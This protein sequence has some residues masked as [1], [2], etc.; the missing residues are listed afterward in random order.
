MQDQDQDQNQGPKY[1]LNIEGTLYPWDQPT[2]SAADIARLGG[3]DPA[4]GVLIID[5]NNNE[6]QLQPD[7]VIE[8][9]PGLGF[10]KKVR[11]RRGMDINPRWQEELDLLRSQHPDVEFIETGYWVRVGRIARPAGW[12]PSESDVAF[13]IPAVYPG[14]HPYGFYV[15]AGST[16]QGKA[17]GSY[18]EP[19]DPRPPFTGTWGKF[20][21][22][23]EVSDW[24]PGGAARAGSNL[25]TWIRGIRARFEEGA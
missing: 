8:V 20:S 3:W 2:V 12:Q 9:K 21:W 24:K 19:G 10:A 6:R 17:P 14:A 18:T 13:Q 25:L 7:E 1:F 22:Q 4:I 23:P 5:E 16:F 15:P 11:W